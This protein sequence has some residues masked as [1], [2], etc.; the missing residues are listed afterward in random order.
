[1]GDVGTVPEYEVI[2]HPSVTYQGGNERLPFELDGVPKAVSLRIG[3]FNRSLVTGLPDL[4]LDILE[5][6][7]LVYSIDAAASRGGPT[8]RQLGRAWYRT[9]NVKMP[10]R[11]IATWQNDG[12]RLALEEMLEFLSGDRF[13]FSFVTG[14]SLP[15]ESRWFDFGAE[16]GWRAD[17]VLM[18]SG[19][20]DSYAGALQEIVEHRQK[21][22]LVSHA[23][24]T[25]IA[26]VQ[27]ALVET[28]QDKLGPDSCRHFQMRIQLATGTNKE[29]THRTRSFLFAALGLVTALAFNR[30]RVSFHENGIIS[31]N[32]PPVA[33]VVNTRATRTTHPQ[34]LARFSGLFG[35]LLQSEIQIDNPSFWQ[36]KTEVVSAVAR[37]GMA[38]QIAVTA[39]CADSHNRTVQHPHCGRC[40]QCI[41]RRFAVLAA[42]LEAYDPAEAYALDLLEG[43]RRS[44]TEKELALSYLRNALTFEAIEPTDLERL[45]PE[46]H[47]TIGFLDGKA[48]ATLAR[49]AALLSRHGTAVAGVMRGITPVPSRFPEDSLPRLFGDVRRSQAFGPVTVPFEIPAQPEATR[50]SLIIDRT[51]GRMLI[52]GIM[53]L[54]KGA[55][56]DLLDAL[57]ESFL[58]AAGKGLAP[59]DYPLL[60][61]GVLAKR[62]GLEDEA[63]V[64]KRINRAKSVL[65]TKF[66]SASLDEHS[67]EDLIENVP[68]QGYRL[69]PDRVEVR[70]G[71]VD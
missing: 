58:D 5:I 43:R 37:L 50:V 49:L 55:T 38:D 31:L 45:F 29:G 30:D 68:W 61:A 18:F 3:G 17:R 62:F 7:A 63:S 19:G 39:S 71:P 60:P 67:G 15:Q 2:C 1:L 16:K 11:C 25:K 52:A 40:S 34:A 44:G 48:E 56:Y 66:Y 46:I 59:L 14:A 12:L 69:S 42:G 28:L 21:V 13:H 6:A 32:L 4:A 9:F 27:R 54:Q 26:P 64:R 65:R 41:D 47:G 10:V 24:S 8:D 51:R 57:A 70:Y 22:A 33:N 36:T 53:T 23:S 35:Q 20:L